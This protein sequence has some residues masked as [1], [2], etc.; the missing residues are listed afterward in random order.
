MVAYAML[1]WATMFLTAKGFSFEEAAYTVSIGGLTSIA[2]SI[3]VGVLVQQFGSRPVIYA[4]SIGLAG[5]R[6]WC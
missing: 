2:A 5:R 1:N 4:M 6:W 3:A